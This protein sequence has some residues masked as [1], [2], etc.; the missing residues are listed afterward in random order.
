VNWST[1]L[2]EGKIVWHGF[3][4]WC[5]QHVL[6]EFNYTLDVLGAKKFRLWNRSCSCIQWA[7]YTLV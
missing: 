5:L 7:W 2:L 6:E 4:E 3:L 1:E